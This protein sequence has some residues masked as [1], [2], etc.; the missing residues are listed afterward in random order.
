ML[1]VIITFY[2]L[3]QKAIADSPADSKITYAHIRTAL[4]PTIQKV[5]DTKYVMPREPADKINAGYQAIID[6]MT[7]EFQTLTDGI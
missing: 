2:N 6:E 4:A 5:V 7:T 1:K 3:S